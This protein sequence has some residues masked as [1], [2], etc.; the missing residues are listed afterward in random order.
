[1]QPTTLYAP[2]T[3]SKTVNGR[4]KEQKGNWGKEKDKHK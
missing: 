1:M 3:D 2:N 4:E